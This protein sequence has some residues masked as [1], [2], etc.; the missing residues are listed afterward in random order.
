MQR[1]QLSTRQR[2]LYAF[3]CEPPTQ[4]PNTSIDI[5]AF[6]QILGILIHLAIHTRPDIIYGMSILAAH[7][8]HPTQYHMDLA[9]RILIYVKANQTLG[10][11]FTSGGPIQLFGHTDALFNCHDD[12][13][14]I[15][16]KIM[17][18]ILT[19][20]IGNTILFP[21]CGHCFPTLQT[22]NLDKNIIYITFQRGVDLQI[23]F[24]KLYNKY[25]NA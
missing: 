25:N 13:L 7:T 12:Q 17:A 3:T 16:L 1:T 10:I 18:N 4:L 22:M 9:I 20:E 15:L 23:Q 2:N 6:R 21:T 11:T 24:F 19:K 5:T 8:S 14:L